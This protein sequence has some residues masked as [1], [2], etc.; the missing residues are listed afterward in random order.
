M[1]AATASH[2][3]TRRRGRARGGAALMAAEYAPSLRQQAVASA[4]PPARGDGQ[5]GARDEAARAA[6]SDVAQGVEIADVDRV[7]DVGVAPPFEELPHD[8][9][10]E[11]QRG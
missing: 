8:R 6:D 1:N 11:A 9:E 5:H 2:S 10:R 3:A 4:G 7:V